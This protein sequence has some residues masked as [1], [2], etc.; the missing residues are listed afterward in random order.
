MWRPCPAWT[1]PVLLR[2]HP[3]GF[4]FRRDCPASSLRVGC[5]G[6]LR[7]RSPG[8]ETLQ[9]RPP[10][11]RGA[12]IGAGGDDRVC[13]GSLWSSSLSLATSRGLTVAPAVPFRPSY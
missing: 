4:A 11:S 2:H 1:L 8:R 10:G 3:L 6:P 9:Q 12:S 5:L 7:P 13:G